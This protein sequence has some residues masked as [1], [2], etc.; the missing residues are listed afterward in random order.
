[1]RIVTVRDWHG[2]ARKW[3]LERCTNPN[4]RGVRVHVSTGYNRVEVNRRASRNGRVSSSPSRTPYPSDSPLLPL[5]NPLKRVRYQL[6]LIISLSFDWARACHLRRAVALQRG[7]GC[8]GLEA[9][10]EVHGL[11]GRCAHQRGEQHV[12]RLLPLRL[13][14]RRSLLPHPPQSAHP[15]YL[16]HGSQLLY[17]RTTVRSERTLDHCL[18]L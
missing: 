17:A 11:R 14:R 16:Q 9:R 5:V 13:R 10:A 12:A 3:S 18:T 4:C 15:L 2:A 7:R 6:N 1:L 8:A